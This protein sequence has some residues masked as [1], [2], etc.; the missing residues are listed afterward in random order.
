MERFEIS[1]FGRQ[2]AIGIDL[3]MA[4]DECLSMYPTIYQ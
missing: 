4:R 2:S 3:W 1:Y